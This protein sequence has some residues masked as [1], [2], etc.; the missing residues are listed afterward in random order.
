MAEAN[1]NLGDSPVYLDEMEP[2]GNDD[3]LR[4]LDAANVGKSIND[5]LEE[6]SNGETKKN[7]TKAVNLFNDV[8]KQ[9]HNQCG[10]EFTALI[11]LEHEKLP[12]ELARFFMVLKK[13]DGKLYNASSLQTY[14][15]SLARFLSSEKYHCPL[16]IKKDVRFKKVREVLKL[17]CTTS[18]MS[19][20]RPGVNSSSAV[21]SE[22]VQAAYSKGTMG[23]GNPRALITTVH[24]LCM[25][26]FGCRANKE[27]YSILNSDIVHGPIGTSGFPEYLELSERVTKTRRGGVNDVR[28]VNGRIYLDQENESICPVRTILYF[29]EKKTEKQLHPDFPFFLTAKQAAEKF[30]E[31]ERYWYSDQRMG[32]NTISQLFKN[33]FIKAGVDTGSDRITGTSCRKTLVQA[34]AESLVPGAFLS[35]M[36]G[37][38]NIDS[39]LEY[40]RNGESTHKAASLAIQRTITGAPNMS[41]FGEV[42]NELK[43][44]TVEGS[45]STSNGDHGQL[46]SPSIMNSKVDVPHMA[47]PSINSRENSE[48]MSIGQPYFWNH[49][50]QAPMAGSF[51]NPQFY[52]PIFTPPQVPYYLPVNGYMPQW[53]NPGYPQ[54]Q[55]FMHGYG[56][57]QQ[58]QGGVSWAGQ[59]SG[60]PQQWGMHMHNVAVSQAVQMHPVHQPNQ[61]Y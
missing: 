20:A 57:Y 16:D 48:Q 22:S 21:S 24:S 8:M 18:A 31:K 36:M 56:S 44:G 14:Y 27:T 25:T 32:I 33:A 15:Q 13:K 42:Y 45:E 11:E 26:G 3:N 23:R 35:K 55:Q 12:S 60:V 50:Y 17:R 29:Q 30:P 7:T 4:G 34:G 39:K 53:N 19:G 51:Y 58:F 49:G 9:Y 43:N 10:S 47:G 46:K 59:V 61:Y 41:S 37:Q 6:N 38:K 1:F 28:D 40:L 2:H 54:H 52:Q 5:F